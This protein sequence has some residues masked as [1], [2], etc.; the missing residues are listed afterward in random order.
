MTYLSARSLY[1][2]YSCSISEHRPRL[3]TSLRIVCNAVDNLLFALPPSTSY[4]YARWRSRD[5]DLECKHWVVLS[6]LGNLSNLGC[7]SVNK[8]AQPSS[9]PSSHPNPHPSSH[10]NCPCKS[11]IKKCQ[12]L[13]F[14]LRSYRWPFQKGISAETQ[15]KTRVSNFVNWN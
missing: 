14:I 1:L 2:I 12:K 5:R 11:S 7:D 3:T 8:N 6:T 13:Q 4:F 15:V 10:P 9:H